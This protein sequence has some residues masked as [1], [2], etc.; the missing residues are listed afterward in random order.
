M[1]LNNT[2]TV[3]SQVDLPDAHAVSDKVTEHFPEYVMLDRDKIMK[4]LD[5]VIYQMMVAQ[6]EIRMTLNPLITALGTNKKKDSDAFW[7]ERV[8][9]AGERL[10]KV[11]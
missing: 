3:Q 6:N 4:D 10:A 5:Q 2:G 8:K 7:N 9:E 11:S 1:T